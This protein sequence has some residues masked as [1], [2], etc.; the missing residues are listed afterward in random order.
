LKGGDVA[1]AGKK[2]ALRNSDALA[3]RTRADGSV[4]EATYRKLHDLIECRQLLPG[5][6]I[7]ECRLALSLKVSRTLLRAGISRL[8][9]EGKLEQLSNG[10]VVVRSIGMAELHELIQLRLL[11]ERKAASLA[12]TRIGIEALRAINRRSKTPSRPPRPA[13]RRTGPWT[14]KSTTRSPDIAA[15]GR[16][17]G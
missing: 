12:A 11:L 4:T 8:L 1:S 17:K 13:R 3:S 9:G 5:E 2:V 6:V 16:S 7:E 15:T 14:M 10:S